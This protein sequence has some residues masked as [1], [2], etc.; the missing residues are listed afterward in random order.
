[1]H[2]YCYYSY[3]CHCCCFRDCYCYYY[4]NYSYVKIQSHEFVTCHRLADSLFIPAETA[5]IGFCL[6]QLPFAF[7]QGSMVDFPTCNLQFKVNCWIWILIQSACPTSWNV[8]FLL[9][10]RMRARLR[11][12]PKARKYITSLRSISPTVIAPKYGV[13]GAQLCLQES[14][15]VPIT[16]GG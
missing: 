15:V 5:C 16:G 4:C 14:F 7:C 12:P 2:Y 13:C 6:R 1:M 10:Q 9:Y 8:F 3:N 11:I